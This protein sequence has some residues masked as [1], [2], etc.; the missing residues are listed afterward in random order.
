MQAR[1]YSDYLNKN[2]VVEDSFLMTGWNDNRRFHVISNS[3]SIKQFYEVTKFI[4]IPQLTGR[5]EYKNIYFFLSMS[6]NPGV[7]SLH[8]IFTQIVLS[9]FLYSSSHNLRK[10]NLIPKLN[11]IYFPTKHKHENKAVQ[12][13]N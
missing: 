2:S 4:N 12:N 13:L 8:D 7:G 10:K 1:G 11:K 9:E 6:H 5:V 3:K